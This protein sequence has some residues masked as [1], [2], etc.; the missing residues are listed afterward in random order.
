MYYCLTPGPDTTTTEKSKKD[1]I[2][3]QPV[4]FGDKTKF[5]YQ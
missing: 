2:V 5:R 4:K 3:I 1:P